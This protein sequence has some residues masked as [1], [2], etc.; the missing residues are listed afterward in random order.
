MGYGTPF[1]NAVA[2]EF[3]TYV[4]TAYDD[5]AVPHVGFDVAGNM[6]SVVTDG[7]NAFNNGSLWFVWVDYI[8]SQTQILEVRVSA[9]STRPADY[10]LQYSINLYSTLGK[11]SNLY[12]GFGGATG[13]S[14]ESAAVFYWQ[15]SVITN[16]DLSSGLLGKYYS[17]NQGISEYQSV[18][19]PSG[20]PLA[21]TFGESINVNWKLGSPAPGVGNSYWSAIFEG[22]MTVASSTYYNFY[23]S[24][25]DGCRLYVSG[26]LVFDGWSSTNSNNEVA[27]Q[28]YLD[29][30]AYYPVRVEYFN[31]KA[32]GGLSI[33]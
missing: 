11:S 26:N 8:G 12:L 17:I 6:H 24:S 21:E 15:F 4:D 9:S 31:W 14:A 30:A 7:S 29:S 23:V 25:D 27:S 13:E 16:T 19:L 5:P 22:F 20:P 28:I 33:T 3:D 10:T 2:V 32:P 18:P 1:T